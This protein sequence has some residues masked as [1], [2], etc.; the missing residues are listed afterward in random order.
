MVTQLTE[1]FEQIGRKLDNGKQI[2][3]IYLD[4]WFVVSLFH[5]FPHKIFQN[6]TGLGK[7]SRFERIVSFLFVLVL[8]KIFQ[9]AECIR[10]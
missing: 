7:N 9:G 8:W 5:Y 2:D 4:M 3:V 6:L 1:V 10:I